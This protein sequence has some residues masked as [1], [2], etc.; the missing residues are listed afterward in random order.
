M[1]P[2]GFACF[3]FF[4]GERERK[5]GERGE[6]INVK[7]LNRPGGMRKIFLDSQIL[8]PKVVLSGLGRKHLDKLG[9]ESARNTIETA[10]LSQSYKRD[11]QL[12]VDNFEMDFETFGVNT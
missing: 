9:E 12:G 3:V 8:G 2:A 11:S 6:G 1:C 7:T 10:G 4:L 5:G